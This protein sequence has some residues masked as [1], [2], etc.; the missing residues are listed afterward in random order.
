LGE[1]DVIVPRLAS[2]ARAEAPGPVHLDL[3]APVPSG[4]WSE[5]AT[6]PSPASETADATA[7]D[8]ALARA[9]DGARRPV[10]I[11]GSL[12]TRRAWGA[13]LGALR[14]PVFTTVAA[15]GVV[16][17]T[18][19]RA[20]GIFTGDG[21][22]LAPETAV[23]AEADLV[24]GLGL[25]PG[26]I[27]GVRPFKAPLLLLDEI[28]AAGVDGLA[29]TV[30]SANAAAA[31]FDGLLARLSAREW[32]AD[33][34]AEA[35][36]RTQRQLVTSEWL[37]G[38]VFARL[39]LNAPDLRLVADTGLFC[40]VAE[41]VWPARRW[42][43]FLG[44][45]NGRYMGTAIPMALG[46]A[47]ADPTHPIACVVGDG[48]WGYVAELQL[49]VARRLPMLL[50][51]LSDGRYGSLAAAPSASNANPAT[52]AL[53]GR[54]WRRTL[55]GMGWATQAVGERAALETALGVWDPTS[56]PLFLEATFD[57]TR[58]A[59]MTEGVR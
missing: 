6:A 52:L 13:R 38:A 30:R 22:P 7:T 43:D 57:P 27:L 41:H 8:D 20:A 10:V 53:P 14:V 51:F 5:A 36:A 3:F 35:R 47:V 26:E 39:A 54:S 46:A 40:T 33:L 55:E 15:K 16:D 34:V 25:R 45:A 50:I 19:G 23:L 12:A 56:G 18:D 58:Y 59:A 2:G 48:G 32:G 17:E 29:P 9:L 28:E 44:S 4:D 21:G 1:P 11:A 31:A 37:P 24:I 49:A 42:R